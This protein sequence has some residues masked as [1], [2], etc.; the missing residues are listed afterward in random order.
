MQPILH[1]L[2]F[3]IC[4]WKCDQNSLLPFS[5]EAFGPCTLTGITFPSLVWWWCSKNMFHNLFPLQ[6]SSL[7][8]L[9]TVSKMKGKKRWKVEKIIL[10]SL[11]NTFPI[12][13]FPFLPVSLV[14][15]MRAISNKSL[16]LSSSIVRG[17]ED[18]LHATIFMKKGLFT[19]WFNL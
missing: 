7:P 14:I 17:T 10:D 13:L 18:A 5:S 15:W 6:E 1:R 4:V 16:L 2:C 8:E 19:L 11:W 12:Q 9:F 3:S